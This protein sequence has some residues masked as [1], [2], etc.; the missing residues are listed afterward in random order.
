MQNGPVEH[1]AILLTA[2]SYHFVLSI[3]GWSLKTGF[4]VLNLKIPLV[5][6]GLRSD[7]IG[8]EFLGLSYFTGIN[9]MCLCFC[10]MFKQLN[11]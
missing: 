2:L 6:E 4:T 3:F 9:Y 8:Q 10:L 11:A 1:S 5:Y 7:L